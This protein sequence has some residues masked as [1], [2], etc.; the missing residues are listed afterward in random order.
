MAA[1]RLEGALKIVLSEEEWRNLIAESTGSRRAP[2]QALE[3]RRDALGSFA[4]PPLLACDDGIEYWVKHP[5]VSDGCSPCQ[6]T[7]QLGGIVTD[8]VVGLLAGKIAWESVPP[9]RVVNMPAELIQIEQRLA[10]ACPGAAHGSKNVSNNCTGKLSITHGEYHKLPMNRSRVA[11]LAI[12]YGLAFASDHQ[13]IVP[14]GGDPLLFS[15]DHGHFFWGGPAWNAA[16]L[17][18]APVAA[19]DA[20]IVSECGL[21]ADE[22]VTPLERLG[23]LT[24]TD[25]AQ[26][27]TAPPDEW[28]FPETDRI[29]VAHYLWTRRDMILRANT[30]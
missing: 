10:S 13:V 6:R 30:C 20:M 15:V 29:A 26:A 2:V 8:H 21:T 9:V 19:V 14:L 23:S 3:Y 1:A 4:A 7:N 28:C 27:V 25:I 22:L 17:A 11:S 24:T 18:S 5:L 12:L 16:G